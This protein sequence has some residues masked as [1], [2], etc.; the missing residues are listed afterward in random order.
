M[1]DIIKIAGVQMD[2]QLGDSDAN[3]KRME[4][5]LKAT[6][7]EALARR[8]AARRGAAAPGRRP[9]AAHGV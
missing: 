2:V 9:L 8:K 7:H 1:A 6:A 3:L 4:E 5:A